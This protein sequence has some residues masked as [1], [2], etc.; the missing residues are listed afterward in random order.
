VWPFKPKSALTARAL[1][2]R[3][4]RPIVPEGHASLDAFEAGITSEEELRLPKTMEKLAMDGVERIY[5]V[6]RVELEPDRSTLAYLDELLDAEMLHK[7][8]LEQDPN[9][10][11]NLFRVVC[12]EF[13]CIVGAIYVRA[14]KG[15]WE[16]RR[17]PNH[18]RS[19]L[20]LTNGESYDP[21]VAVVRQLSDEREPGGLERAF[22][23]A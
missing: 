4:F 15:Q 11:R 14:G 7:L 8:T 18:W 13:G 6:R 5:Q 17:G 2:G 1:H 10:A 19:T 23:A 12:T 22:D 20:R 9:H 16:L 21:F 3:W